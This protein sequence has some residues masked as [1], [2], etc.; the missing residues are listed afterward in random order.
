MRDYRDAKAMAH[1]LRDALLE[2]NVSLSHS[3]SLEL[4]AKTLGIKDWNTLAA[5]IST[6]APKAKSSDKP[7]RGNAGIKGS[8]PM[9]LPLVPL[10]DVLVFPNM[11]L[12]IFAGRCKTIHAL[13]HAVKTGNEVFLVAQKLEIDEH[14]TL[15]GLHTVGTV[16]SVLNTATSMDEEGALMAFVRGHYRGVIKELREREDFNLVTVQP[17]DE[18]A[19][20]T[21][22]TH[23]LAKELVDEAPIFF[24]A[25]GWRQ[26]SWR[27]KIAGDPA[28]AAD[29]MAS[30]LQRPVSV[31]QDLLATLNVTERIEKILALMRQELRAA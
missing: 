17:A 6:S 16:G 5:Q 29:A 18:F 23:A 22:K 4:V 21:E 3:E 31:R 13:E 30:W 8:A 19:G 20:D 11:T 12:P 24:E 9:T 10:R 26:P 28:R 7:H 25:R 2:K 1:T 27:T 14:P 15:D